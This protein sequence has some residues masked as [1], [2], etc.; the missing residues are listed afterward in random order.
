MGKS[1]RASRFPV[2][3]TAAHAQDE[4]NRS[5]SPKF[6]A[7]SKSLVLHLA[8]FLLP[9]QLYVAVSSVAAGVPG[10]PCLITSFDVKSYSLQHRT[11]AKLS[12]QG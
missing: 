1:A 2:Y 10:L 3:F 8:V 5:F 12:R 4:I 7:K 9:S 11:Y 6:Q